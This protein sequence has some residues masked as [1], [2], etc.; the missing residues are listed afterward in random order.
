[1]LA[2]LNGHTK[3]VRKLLRARANIHARDE[4]SVVLGDNIVWQR[5]WCCVHCVVFMVFVFDVEWMDCDIF[6]CL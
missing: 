1:M 2:A 4:V 3:T 6:C 5:L